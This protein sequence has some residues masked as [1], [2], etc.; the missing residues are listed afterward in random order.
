MYQQ[1][2]VTKHVRQNRGKSF[3]CSQ[4]RA[5]VAA[6]LII[7]ITCRYAQKQCTTDTRIRTQLIELMLQRLC[8]AA[9][10]VSVKHR[11]MGTSSSSE[12]PST[13]IEITILWINIAQTVLDNKL[14]IH[15]TH[16]TLITVLLGKSAIQI[17]LN[18]HHSPVVVGF[19]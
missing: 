16:S 2:V 5:V 6:G 11:L 8:F 14:Q 1:H 7:S 12:V 15:T 19:C 17:Y 9:N 4:W 13:S 18:A 10:S 3:L